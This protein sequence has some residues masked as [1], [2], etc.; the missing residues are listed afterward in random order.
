MCFLILPI[1][2]GMKCPSD[3]I[4]WCAMFGEAMPGPLVTS[5][6]ALLPGSPAPTPMVMVEIPAFL[7]H[8]DDMGMVMVYGYGYEIGSTTVLYT[9]IYFVN[10]CYTLFG[11]SN[12]HRPA[13][14]FTVWKSGDSRLTP[15]ELHQ[16]N[17][18]W[19]L[20]TCQVQA[21][22]IEVRSSLVGKWWKPWWSIWFNEI[23]SG[24]FMHNT[25]IYISYNQ[26]SYMCVCL[27]IGDTPSHGYWIMWNIMIIQWIQWATLFLDKHSSMREASTCPSQSW[28][29]WQAFYPDPTKPLPEPGWALERS[30]VERSK[31]QSS[32]EENNG[33]G[34][35]PGGEAKKDKKE[36]RHIKTSMR[37]FKVEK[38]TTGWWFGT[39]I[40]WF[41]I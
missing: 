2:N 6:E 9:S 24:Y 40:V 25:Y 18:D 20:C 23:Q 5:S 3:W 7:F 15:K 30:S 13:I 26:H 27:K 39:W 14:F 22:R 32:V 29:C 33:T 36:P 31:T 38:N 12:I 19:G 35:L 8:G 28:Q 16:F 21:L 1:R 17:E 4:C 10:L 41:S 34:S 11:A 37:L